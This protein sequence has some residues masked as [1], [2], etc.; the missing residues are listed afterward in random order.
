MAN[1]K[2]QF[3]MAVSDGDDA[4]MY[5]SNRLLSIHHEGDD[6]VKL[7]FEPGIGD[8]ATGADREADSIDLT[9]PNETE[10]SVT[11]A[12]IDA[13]NY[14]YGAYKSKQRNYMIVKSDVDATMD[15]VSGI[16]SCAISRAAV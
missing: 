11:L 6:V 13:L 7:Y 8:A 2:V 15:N 4:V 5:P 10:R 12:V 9:V 14:N 3:I 1:Q 16:T